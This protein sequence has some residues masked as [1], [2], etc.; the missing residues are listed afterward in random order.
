MRMVLL[1]LAEVGQRHF[2][3]IDLRVD[4]FG[5]ALQDQHISE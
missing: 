5:H 2:Q 4:L 3:D 1:D